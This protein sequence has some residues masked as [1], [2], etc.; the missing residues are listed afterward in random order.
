VRQLPALYLGMSEQ[1]L[2]QY[3]YVLV[4]IG[5]IVEG[6]ATLLTAAFL[7]HQ[8]YFSLYGVILTAMV[9]S[10]IF[11]EAIFHAARR[12]GKPFLDRKAARHPRYAGVQDWVCRRSVLLL[13]VSRYLFGFRMAIPI[14]CGA[15]GMRPLLFFVLNIV[16]AVLWAVPLGLAG[17]VFGGVLAAFW[18]GIK[19][20]EWHIA[21]GLIVVLTAFLAWYDPELRRFAT[22]VSHTRHAA[23]VSVARVRRLLAGHRSEPESAT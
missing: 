14:A 12:R 10:A 19:Y 5:S 13:L 21:T 23:V 1:L 11:N 3:G 16:G 2:T 7:A 8:H 20:Y 18:Q 4:F 15:V 9:A 22:L 6:D 17:Y